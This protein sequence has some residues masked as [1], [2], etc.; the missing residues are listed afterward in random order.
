MHGR[1]S[2]DAPSQA[3]TADHHTASDLRKRAKA[4]GPGRPGPN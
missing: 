4:D 1:K 3:D 2:A